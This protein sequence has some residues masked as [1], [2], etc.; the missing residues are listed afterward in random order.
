MKK[1]GKTHFDDLYNAQEGK[2]IAESTLYDA[3]RDIE[4][5]QRSFQ[6]ELDHWAKEKADLIFAR[7][8]AII[9]KADAEAKTEVAEQRVTAILDRLAAKKLVKTEEWW[10]RD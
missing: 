3:E 4:A 8:S 6:E 5:D 1:K 10:F 2:R 9:A 7:D